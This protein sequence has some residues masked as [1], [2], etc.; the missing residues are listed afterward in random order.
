MITAVRWLAV[1]LTVTVLVACGITREAHPNT[2]ANTA[3][4][5]FTIGG[6]APAAGHEPTATFKI[7]DV[8]GST[9]CN[10]W[11]ASYTFDAAT[12]KLVLEGIGMSAAACLD[13]AVSRTEAA[14]STALTSVNQASI[15]P[16]GRLVLSGPGGEIVFEVAAVAR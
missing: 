15:D 9:G 3:W 12:G 13:D 8:S 4:R 7:A 2:L 6:V 1:L 5:A 10:D 16:T 11:F 14:F